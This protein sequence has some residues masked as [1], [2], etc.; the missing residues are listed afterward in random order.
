MNK[1][2][3][4]FAD[5]E[6]IKRDRYLVDA[7]G[8]ILGRLATKVATYLRGKHKPIFSPQA[9]CGDYITV[10]NAQKI[11]VTG[12]KSKQK[13]YFSH[14][15]YPGGDKLLSFEKLLATQPEKII[16][17]AVTGMLAHNRLGAKILKKLKVFKGLPAEYSQWP[18]LEV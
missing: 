8:K 10:V 6:K 5:G 9:D 4:I 12:K 11:K 3:T 7:T 15:G 1:K 16:R 2:Q 13:L 18:K 17:R 14:S